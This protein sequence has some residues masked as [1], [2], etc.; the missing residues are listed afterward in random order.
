M[1]NEIKMLDNEV[2]YDF[3]LETRKEGK[4]AVLLYKEIFKSDNDDQAGYDRVDAAQARNAQIFGVWDY[5]DG[6]IT[7]ASYYEVV[8]PVH[9]PVNPAKSVYTE[10]G[11][12]N[13]R[14]YLRCLAEE[15]E[16]P[17]STVVMLSQLLGED[18][19]FDGLVVAV[20][21]AALGI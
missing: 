19:D 17:L 9:S 14:D 11:Y 16:V 5:E 6:E 8:K 20:E 15:N 21:D 3:A 4:Q 18:E 2:A 1:I 7:G 10:N 13:R 12:D